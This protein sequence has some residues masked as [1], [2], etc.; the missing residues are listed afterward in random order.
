MLDALCV[1]KYT[2]CVS[3]GERHGG[4]QICTCKKRAF[5]RAQDNTYQ[6]ARAVFGFDLSGNVVQVVL[7]RLAHG[8]DWR[9]GL[10]KGD[11]R[12]ALFNNQLNVCG[13]G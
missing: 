13:H 5:I 7:P 3:G 12:N 4:S 11:V 2:G 1:F 10:V 9:V 8:V 6:L